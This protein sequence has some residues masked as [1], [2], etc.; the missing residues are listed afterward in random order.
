MLVR[1]GYRRAYED[2]RAGLT[3]V[4]DERDRILRSLEKHR[5]GKSLPSRLGGR[6]LC[7]MH[8]GKTAGTSIQQALFEARRDAAISTSR[9]KIPTPPRR[10]SSRSAMS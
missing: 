5:L 9:R 3:L 2:C 10:R 6:Q 4:R 1:T 8:I 7:F